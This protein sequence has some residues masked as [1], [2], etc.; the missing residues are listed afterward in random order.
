LRIE[1]LE[2]RLVLTW[3]GV[4]PALITPPSNPA[5][6]T[7]LQND[8]SGSATIATTEVDYYSF[9]ATAGGSYVISAT[10]PVS[11]VDTVLGVFSASGQRLAYNDDIV[12]GT[13]N[14]S[15]LTINLTTGTR[16]L[17]G[18]TNYTSSSRGSYSWSIDGPGSSAADDAYENNDSLA[19]A[20]NLGTLSATRMISGLVLADAQ[21]WFRFTTGAAGTSASSVSLSFQN[22]Q[23]NLQLALYNSGG[24]LLSASQGSGNTEAISL[25]GRAA[26]T[27]YVQIYGGSG[28]TNPNYLL[29]INPPVVTTPPPPS[30]GAFQ[31]AL[32]MS[33]L[34]ASQQSI[35]NQAADRWERVVV[36]DLPNTTY[37]GLSVDDLLIH[38]S[39]RMI[40]GVGGILGQAGPDAFR[41]VGRLPY[42]GVMQFDSADMANMERNGTLLGVVMHEI[43]HILGIGTLWQSLG[44]VSGAS[45]SNPIFTGAQ[46]RS[47]YNQL[48]GVTASGVPVEN[49]G[50]PGTRDSH[51]RET[52]FRNEI[53]TG[54]VG[55]GTN[56]PVSRVTVASL[57]DMGYQVNYAMADSFTPTSTAIAAAAQS[58]GGTSYSARLVG[59]RG[60]SRKERVP[61]AIGPFHAFPRETL[62][63][64]VLQPTPVAISKETVD[65][66]MSTAWNRTPDAPAN[67][68]PQ[69]GEPDEADNRLAWEALE[70]VWQALAPIVRHEFS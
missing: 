42:H 62:R 67:L 70:A 22:A 25:N 58:S 60:E 52:I 51:W 40:D 64:R 66:V 63:R 33:G 48:F 2:P 16:Y 6:V 55:P 46:A 45:S 68:A 13:N 8:A 26:G 11:S 19:A 53:M 50:G 36:G 28:A 10:T 61:D 23:G 27:Y 24:S 41:A 18:I 30:T 34:T 1:P 3:A 49:T 31:I 5:Q 57:A 14:D 29:S 56:L 37:Q 47:A 21:D 9:R 65:A 39:A 20:Y 44:L 59:G 43:G 32:S 7:L 4:P 35:F 12:S 69:R 38:A 15:R 17:I 54:W